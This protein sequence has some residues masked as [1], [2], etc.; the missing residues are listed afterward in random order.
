MIATA[1][2]CLENNRCC[3]WYNKLYDDD[4]NVIHN[5]HICEQRPVSPMN[6]PLNSI[7][8]I[9]THVSWFTRSYLDII[10]YYYYNN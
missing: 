7:E 9:G 5:I 4:F 2:V 3:S 1:N 6:C 10:D 8:L